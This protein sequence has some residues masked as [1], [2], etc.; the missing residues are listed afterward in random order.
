MQNY[1]MTIAY[2]GRRYKGFRKIKG[3][4]DATIQGKIERILSKLYET[5]VEIISA[6]NTDAGVNAKY[7]VINFKAPSNNVDIKGIRDYME[8][9]LP[10]D[11]IT[12]SIEPVDDRFHSRYNLKSITYEYRLWKKD[13][14]FRP[15]FQRHLVKRMDKSLDVEVMKEAATSF[16]G[17]HDFKAFSTKSKVKSSVKNIHNLTVEE[18]DNEIVIS[19]TANGFLINMERIIVGTLIQIGLH[20]RQTESIEKAFKSMNNKDAGHKAM[21]GALCLVDVKY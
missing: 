2:E 9:Y 18:T 4:D 21:A 14:P 11:I 15:L 3:Q 13:A 1:K 17:E 7:Q 10:D 8:E 19:I 5:D 6:V 12:L 16:I 20:E